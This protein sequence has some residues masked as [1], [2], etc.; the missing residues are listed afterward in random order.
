MTDALPAIDRIDLKILKALQQDGRLSNLGLAEQVGL[1]DLGPHL[2]GGLEGVHHIVHGAVEQ[3][4]DKHQQARAQLHR[5]Q[6]RLIAEDVV[7]AVQAL[8]AFQH[9]GG[10]QV[11]FFGQL[12][13]ADAAVGLQHA[14]DAAVDLV[15]AAVAARQAGVGGVGAVVS[16][17]HGG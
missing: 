2:H 8:H 1:Q 11:H 3:D 16:G 9:C 10:R 4:L 6:P 7:F 12:E 14:Q 17:V 5:V 15:Q 13:V